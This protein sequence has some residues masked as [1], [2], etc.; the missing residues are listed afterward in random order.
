MFIPIFI[1]TRYTPPIPVYHGGYA[2]FKPIDMTPVIV[3]GDIAMISDNLGNLF[4][5]KN[6]Q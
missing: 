5:T 3:S 1:P 2:K 6:R 4:A